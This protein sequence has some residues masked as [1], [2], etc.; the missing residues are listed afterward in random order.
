[1]FDFI[2]VPIQR[3]RVICENIKQNNLFRFCFKKLKPKT[4][5]I[6]HFF[7][8]VHIRRILNKTRTDIVSL[9]FSPSFSLIHSSLTGYIYREVFYI[10]TSTL[11][12]KKCDSCTLT[13]V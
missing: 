1:M 5:I 10:F 2:P 8:S 9:P 12:L 13:N 11:Y 6:G 7:A 3:I 4:L